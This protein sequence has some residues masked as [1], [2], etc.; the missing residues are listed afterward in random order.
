[1]YDPAESNI[2]LENFKESIIS[3]VR[4]YGTRFIFIPSTAFPKYGK[5]G[6]IRRLL[7][8]LQNLGFLTKAL[9]DMTGV[10]PEDRIAV[11]QQAVSLWGDGRSRD[12]L[13][14]LEATITSADTVMEEATDVSFLVTQLEASATETLRLCGLIKSCLVNK[15]QVHYSKEGLK[16]MMAQ[17]IDDVFDKPISESPKDR[18][19]IVNGFDF[20]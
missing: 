3:I 2:K 16:E 18:Q 6:S 10:S 14:F 11:K 17:M 5:R 19:S 20:G 12:C 15:D 13:Y 7:V 8:K 1:M 4:T 9:T